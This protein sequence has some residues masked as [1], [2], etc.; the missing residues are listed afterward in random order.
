MSRC[1]NSCSRLWAIQGEERGAEGVPGVYLG[2][3]AHA[4]VWSASSRERPHGSSFGGR[5]VQATAAARSPGEK[6]LR[7]P[8]L[9][10]DSGKKREAAASSRLASITGRDT[11]IR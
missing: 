5:P 9:R 3:K 11:R 2:L 7:M 8:D 4:A 10:S 1:Q 6:R